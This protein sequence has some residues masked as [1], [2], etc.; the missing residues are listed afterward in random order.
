MGDSSLSAAYSRN[1]IKSALAK[2]QF[3]DVEILAEVTAGRVEQAEVTG[4]SHAASPI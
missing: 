4:K 2:Q 1:P 3:A